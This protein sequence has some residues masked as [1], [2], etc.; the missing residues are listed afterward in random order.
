MPVATSQK[1][2]DSK[3][4]C[5]EDGYSEAETVSAVQEETETLPYVLSLCIMVG[6]NR[7]SFS[8]HHGSLD[9]RQSL[10][11]ARHE[12]QKK[13]CALWLAASAAISC[14]ATGWH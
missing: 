5:S 3:H 8:S 7:A 12:L 4:Q 13:N 6:C 2:F 1:V 10:E 11:R 14:I 9:D